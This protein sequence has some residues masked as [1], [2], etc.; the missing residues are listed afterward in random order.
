MPRR[1][2]KRGLSL[3][4]HA[5][6]TLRAAPAPE[7]AAAAAAPEVAAA[8]PGAGAA[9]AAGAGEAAREEAAGAPLPAPAT[10]TAA[11][12][13]AAPLPAA[14]SDEAAAAEAAAPLPAPAAVAADA[15]TAPAPPLPA[16][17]DSDDEGFELLPSPPREVIEILDSQPAD[18][19]PAPPARAAVAMPAPELSPSVLGR[20]PRESMEATPCSI[21]T[22][23]LECA[24]E[25]VP[26]AL[27]CGHTFCLGCLRAW[28]RQCARERNEPTCPGCK[29]PLRMEQGRKLFGS[30]GV[31]VVMDRAAVDAAQRAAMVAQADAR[32]A[33]AERDAALR[34]L[35]RL[36]EQL[37]VGAAG[38]A[39][40]AGP[41]PH[42]APLPQPA[43]A[44]GAYAVHKTFRT[45]H[46]SC[47]DLLGDILVAGSSAMAPPAPRLFT[48]QADGGSLG[49]TALSLRSLGVALGGPD[50]R[51]RDLRLGR[52]PQSRSALALACLPG[53]VAVIDLAAGGE[54][55][56]W[57][58]AAQ[59]TCCAW[60]D[61][62]TDQGAFS[63]QHALSCF[64]FSRLA[65]A[66]GRRPMPWALPPRRAGGGASRVLRPP[67]R[68]ALQRALA[69]HNTLRRLG[70]GRREWRQH[71]HFARYRPH[72]TAV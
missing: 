62:G 44:P 32:T 10:D 17:D 64:G 7:T 69:L 9:G 24:G 43:T 3:F 36:E 42:S 68:P 25:R 41:A 23:P 13:A 65:R 55:R 16:D 19:A 21:C 71:S 58:M 33:Q 18:D 27:V 53:R 48:A 51:V 22:E 49:L 72:I 35:R 47:C 50:G 15:A 39:S 28:E 2:R 54:A 37:R 60:A 63:A 1:T 38:I 46:L 61:D 26:F 59:P 45:T 67:E 5:Q 40:A 57:A 31:L 8:E 52:V 70:L 14:A 66:R 12:P 56:S 30:G 29:A 34:S 6:R 11:A 4:P 20:R